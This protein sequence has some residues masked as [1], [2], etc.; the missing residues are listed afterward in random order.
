MSLSA[1]CSAGLLF[2][3]PTISNLF[4]DLPLGDNLPDNLVWARQLSNSRLAGA[5][6]ER[7]FRVQVTGALDCLCLLTS[8]AMHALVSGVAA[9]LPG[10]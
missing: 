10:A 7:Y 6:W 8:E 3:T 5:D 9:A 2:L 4:A 1:D